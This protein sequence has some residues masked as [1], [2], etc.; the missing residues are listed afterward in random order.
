M[1]SNGK[2]LCKFFL[3]KQN[4][5][6]LDFEVLIGRLLRSTTYRTRFRTTWFQ[7]MSGFTRLC[8][9]P[10]LTHS[11]PQSL[12][13][14]GWL[15]WLKHF[16]HQLYTM[17]VSMTCTAWDDV[18]PAG[19]YILVFSSN[20][21]TLRPLT[22]CRLF[23]QAYLY[24]IVFFMCLFHTPLNVFVPK[25]SREKMVKMEFLMKWAPWTRFECEPQTNWMRPAPTRMIEWC[26]CD[27]AAATASWASVDLDGLLQRTASGD[28]FYRDSCRA[29]GK[30][31]PQRCSRKTQDKFAIVSMA[32]K[33]LHR[34]IDA[35]AWVHVHFLRRVCMHLDRCFE[36]HAY[37]G[38]YVKQVFGASAYRFTRSLQGAH[39][40]ACTCSFFIQRW[41]TRVGVFC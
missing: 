34:C 27:T 23:M 9:S 33:F 31:Q 41:E 4:T 25:I 40:R 24:F 17:V 12:N 20:N 8:H 13:V 5:Y 10:T 39:M 2:L 11:Q 19:A 16:E 22:L 28:W 21:G 36:H 35:H 6:F 29:G 38:V 7:C 26:L 37:S 14:Q 30:R 32:T 3:Q 1:M 15:L 18:H